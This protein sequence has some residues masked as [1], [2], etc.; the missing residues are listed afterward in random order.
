VL[1][2][3]QSIWHQPVA[4]PAKNTLSSINTK[5][6]KKTSDHKA[7]EAKL[8]EA[9]SSLTLVGCRVKEAVITKMKRRKKT[10]NGSILTLKRRPRPSLDVPF[11]MKNHLESKSR[12]KKSAKFKLGI[13]GT[14]DL[15]YVDPP[16]KK[17]MNSISL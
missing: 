15:M 4:V 2:K 13:W 1:H 16:T 6:F 12:K 10:L 17:R 11:K 14:V 5:I 7:P 8:G 9:A 3:H